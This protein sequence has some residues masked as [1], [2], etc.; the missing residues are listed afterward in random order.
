MRI[1]LTTDLSISA[2]P[3]PRPLMMRNDM[4]IMK[5]PVRE[6]EEGT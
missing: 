1:V 6:V 5:D 3:S 4:V 2:K